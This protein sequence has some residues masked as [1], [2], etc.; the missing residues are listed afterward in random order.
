MKGYILSAPARKILEIK[1]Q[2]TFFDII[3]LLSPCY[4]R[5]SYPNSYRILMLLLNLPKGDQVMCFHHRPVDFLSRQYS[6]SSA[7]LGVGGFG[8]EHRTA[9]DARN[10]TLYIIPTYD[11]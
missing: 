1:H 10:Y 3:L 7:V 2:Y 11:T 6:G 8:Y 5:I 9:T 4:S